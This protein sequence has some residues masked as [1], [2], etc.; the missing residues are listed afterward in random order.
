MWT[1]QGQLSGERNITW[2]SSWRGKIVFW[3][4]PQ[5]NFSN[6][7]SFRLTD[8]A[9]TNGGFV[10]MSHKLCWD[11]SVFL[12]GPLV[13]GIYILGKFHRAHDGFAAMCNS[14]G[15]G[16]STH[17]TSLWPCKII[18]LPSLWIYLY[19]LNGGQME[20]CMFSFFVCSWWTGEIYFCF[21][22]T[23]FLYS[24]FT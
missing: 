6:K 16:G 13:S 23:L 7:R 9:V 18:E 3:V 4:T 14:E 20:K 21:I 17:V 15:W 24:H 5:G 8:A 1:P 19:S 22:F 11:W 2:D 10:L 12:K